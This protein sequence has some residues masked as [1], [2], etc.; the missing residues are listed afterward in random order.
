MKLAIPIL[1]LLSLG[2]VGGMERRHQAIDRQYQAANYRLD[3][4]VADAASMERDLEIYRME[5][6]RQSHRTDMPTAEFLSVMAD[7]LSRD[8]RCQVIIEKIDWSTW[9]EANR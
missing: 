8:G 9:E 5:I 1:I 2:L 3:R 4:A 6:A 7:Y